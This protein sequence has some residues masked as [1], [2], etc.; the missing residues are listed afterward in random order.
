MAR[1]DEITL[2]VSGIYDAET[3][4]E[5]LSKTLNFPGYY[6]FNFNALWDCMTDEDQSTMPSHLIVT[7]LLDLK[8]HCPE[9]H[10]GLLDCLKAY[11]T[12]F[13]DRRLTLQ[14]G[15]G[16]HHLLPTTEPD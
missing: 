7:G 9:V 6:G 12:E 5:Y 13:P 8:T 4:H 15:T 1:P 2:D 16:F 14:E 10:A 3:L 11:S